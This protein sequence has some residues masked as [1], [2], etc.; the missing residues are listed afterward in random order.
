MKT[1]IKILC[2]I[3]IGTFLF[4]G[5]LL[6]SK[7]M[8][9]DK[10][11][12]DRLAAKDLHHEQKVEFVENEPDETM[13]VTKAATDM[14]IK[15]H[16]NQELLIEDSNNWASSVIRFL[17]DEK[18]IEYIPKLPDPNEPEITVMNCIE[19]LTRLFKLHLKVDHSDTYGMKANGDLILWDTN[20][21]GI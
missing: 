16:K 1:K 6:I 18:T 19:E 9:A 5:A 15:N 14:E 4:L 8:I 7:L 10:E 12:M 2:L 3:I 11:T 20:E 13:Y 17:D 21:T